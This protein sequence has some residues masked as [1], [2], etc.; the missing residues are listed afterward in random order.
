MGVKRKK[1]VYA[2]LTDEEYLELRA[3]HRQ[4]APSLLEAIYIRE[5]VTGLRPHP[6]YQTKAS[7]LTD[8][9][10][11]KLETLDTFLEHAASVVAGGYMGLNQDK[12]VKENIDDFLQ[13]QAK[14]RG[15]YIDDET[16]ERIPYHIIHPELAAK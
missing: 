6:V 2:Y 1:R 9:L 12:V 11:D 10:M 16:D 5:V 15:Y 8:L 4:D 7:I 14:L 13:L 3:Y